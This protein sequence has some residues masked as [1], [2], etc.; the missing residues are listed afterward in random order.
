M[1][2]YLFHDWREFSKQSPPQGLDKL[3]P[4]LFQ[5]GFD[6]QNVINRILKVFSH[7]IEPC[8]RTS[9]SNKKQRTVHRQG[10]KWHRMDKRKFFVFAR[11]YINSFSRRINALVPR[12][13]PFKTAI[14][15]VTHD[16]H[17]LKTMTFYR[18]AEIAY[19]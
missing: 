19:I 4:V 14:G 16:F 2:D 8:K 9:L 10:I 11:Q 17:A 1:L 13:Q 18:V 12:N 7:A 15:M 3:I 5:N 6:P